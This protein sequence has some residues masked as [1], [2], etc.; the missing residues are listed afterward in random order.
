MYRSRLPFNGF[1]SHITHVH[2][3]CF[4]LY[5]L[6]NTE[7]NADIGRRMRN[8]QAW[9]NSPTKQASKPKSINAS[10]PKSSSAE[11]RRSLPIANPSR[12]TETQ[13]RRSP[14]ERALEVTTSISESPLP[15]RP[16][17]SP[18]KRESKTS[19]STSEISNRR[20][21]SRTPTQSE[22]AKNNV[23]PKEGDIILSLSDDKYKEVM[24]KHFNILGKRQ[25]GE[26]KSD[27]TVAKQISRLFKKRLGRSG[28]RFFSRIAQ[29]DMFIVV[30]NEVAIQSKNN[31]C[32]MLVKSFFKFV[33]YIL[34]L[35]SAKCSQK[36]LLIS[37]NE[38]SQSI[39]GFLA[40]VM[41]NMIN[42]SHHSSPLM[43]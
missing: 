6:Y 35:F 37:L 2:F 12:T 11:K 29:S 16:P 27:E 33:T 3:F 14:R 8:Y 24:Y 43:K 34:I 25:S 31:I 42:S 21:S 9:S 36:L 13:P 4:N 5:F 26:T 38:T 20:S 1:G 30:D 23:V 17:S 22:T 39:D 32:G 15:R 18:Q 19:S 10:S 40:V 41:I 7:I 28:G